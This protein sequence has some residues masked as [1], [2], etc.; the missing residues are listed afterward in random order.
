[1]RRSGVTPAVGFVG[2]GVVG[3]VRGARRTVRRALASAWPP[4]RKNLGRR[5]RRSWTVQ[6]VDRRDAAEDLDAPRKQR[7]TARRI[8]DRLIDEHGVGDVSYSMVRAYVAAGRPQIRAEAGRGLAA[9]VRPADASRPGLRPRST[10][11][12]LWFELRGEPVNVLP[13]LAAAVV[14]GQGGAPDLRLAGQE[15]FFEGHVHA[16]SVLGG[17]PTGKIRYDNLKAAV[18]RVLGFGR[19]RVETERWTA[20]RSHY[21]FEAFYC[22]PGI[23]GAHEKGGVE[24][25]IGWFRRNHLVPVPEVDS[26]AELNAL[27]DG[28]TPSRRRPP[29][30]QPAPHR[31]RVLRRRAAAAAR[32]CRTSRSRPADG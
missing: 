14:F 10:S 32:R 29:D 8:L 30:R 31:R 6:A 4:P 25:E 3:A 2:P 17:V 5:G 9:G 16:F 28:G 12:R 24:G 20:F 1:M 13:V 19:D 21:G 7:H 26:L 11:V 15:A 18:A 27:V 22:Q 23:E